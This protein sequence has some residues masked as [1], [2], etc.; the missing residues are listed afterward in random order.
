MINLAAW[1]QLMNSSK[2]TH[3]KKEKAIHVWISPCF[4]I[5]I[6]SPEC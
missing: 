3:F 1:K 6:K 4:S 5:P 2:M